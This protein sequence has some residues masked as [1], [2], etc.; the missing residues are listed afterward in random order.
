MVADTTRVKRI[1]ME[2]YRLATELFRERNIIRSLSF[3]PAVLSKTDT[4]SIN[5]A[6]KRLGGQISTY[7]FNDKCPLLV[8]KFFCMRVLRI[9]KKETPQCMTINL[10]LI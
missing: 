3:I 4:V 7:V 6:I 8:F 10:N 2:K 5:T 1:C 9:K